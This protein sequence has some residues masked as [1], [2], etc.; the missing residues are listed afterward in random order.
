M[1]VYFG[2]CSR[3]GGWPSARERGMTAVA[4]ACTE[5][6]HGGLLAGRLTAAGSH[7]EIWC[8]HAGCSGRLYPE[9]GA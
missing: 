2:F 7:M 4:P 6:V 3:S 5:T 8:R 1:H 9:L